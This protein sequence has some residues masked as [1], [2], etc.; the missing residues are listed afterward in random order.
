MKKLS[1]YLTIFMLNALK[2]IFFALGVS[3]LV[4][5]LQSVKIV[6]G[7]GTVMLIYYAGVLLLGWYLIKKSKLEVKYK[8]IL[9]LA[10]AL[11]GKLL[12]LW[13]YNTVPV[14][15]YLTMYD[16]GKSAA[17]GNFY[18]FQGYSYIAR[19]PHLTG[20]SLYF[21][22]IIKLV[23]D[24]LTIYK[25]INVVMGIIAIYLIYKIASLIFER[26]EVSI[27]ILT[28]TVLYPPFLT[29][30]GVFCSENIAIPFYLGSI[31]FFIK[32]FKGKR[33]IIFICLA[34]VL[35]SVGNL[36]RM[37]AV[38]IVIAMLMYIF[39][40][41]ENS[42]IEKLKKT[43]C[44]VCSFLL[45]LCGTSMIL[46]TSG[47]IDHSLW[48][49]SE[50][51][52][53]NILRGSNIE[54]GGMWNAEDAEAIDACNGDYDKIEKVSKERIKERLTNT[55]VNKLVGF[56]CKKFF[57]Q[58][59]DG[60]NAGIFWS[61]VS[62]PKEDKK[63]EASEGRYIFQTIY[64][65]LIGL[66]LIGVFNR[67]LVK[68]KNIVS[69][70]YI[71]FGGYIAAYLITENQA[72]YSYIISWILLIFSGVGIEL[73]FID[74]KEVFTNEAERIKNLLKRS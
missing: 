55:P 64:T 54:S 62:T 29:Y 14:S 58:W 59:Q 22:A 71:I 35:L 63:F 19:F 56:Y 44:L 21:A 46:K 53:T 27:S 52:I 66:S 24:S 65:L 34:G 33:N 28:L 2:I 1:N 38:I 15:D 57:T 11:L 31:Y 30:T 23:G 45:I 47:V 7:I 17:E 74:F 69:L 32:G 26:E 50:P 48:K 70:F 40:Y 73:L 60:D 51:S 10:T 37:V 20:M 13:N 4:M 12:W 72:R 8:V 67:R 43:I 49:G 68:E 6:S 5:V 25:V 41:S 36:F 61:E 39:I 3:S 42:I 9:L 18:A 16:A